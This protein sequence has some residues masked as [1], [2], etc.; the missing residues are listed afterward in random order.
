MP[1]DQE[2]LSRYSP[3][4]S[5]YPLAIITDEDRASKVTL[6]DGQVAWKS[7][8]RY[9]ELLRTQDPDTGAIRYEIVPPK[10]GE[11]EVRSLISIIAEGERGAEFSELALFGDKLLAFDD[12]TG[13]ICEI[14]DE[15]L[16]VPRQ[17]LMTGPGDAEFKGFKCE[18]VAI[19][20]DEMIVGSHGRP[21]VENGQ[22]VTGNLEWVKQ[23]DRDYRI[24]SLN[25]H[26]NYEAMRRAAG[27][28]SSQ[29]YL[30]HEAAEWHPLYQKWYFFPRKVSFQ[31]FD[32]PRDER[33]RGGNLL[34]CASEDFSD[35][36]ILEVGERVPE[37]GVSSFKVIP[38][39]PD[40]C[41]GLKSVEVDDKTETYAFAFDLKGH[42][43]SEEVYIGPYK[44][45]GV[46][47]L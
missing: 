15:H 46:E 7:T 11:V 19:K 41:I 39:R 42:M 35:I 37:R 5:R 14:R 43:L 38:G 45:E 31:P 40:E 28:D 47:I 2:R 29:G 8:I 24:R 18:W 9:D 4:T 27:I 12:R 44:C 13:L 21:V 30:T 33:E 1:L 16:L 36:D 23:V 10:E 20:G 25:W 26:D 6:E 17:I 3:E 22:T 34:F 32:E